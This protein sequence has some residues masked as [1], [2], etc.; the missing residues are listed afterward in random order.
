MKHLLI[1][2][3]FLSS[4]AV[5]GDWYSGKGSVSPQAKVY[6]DRQIKNDKARKFN[7]EQMKATPTYET[8]RERR[9]RIDDSYD[10]YYESLQ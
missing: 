2:L 7:Y 1:L 10:D 9:Q 4:Y 5:A 8:E 6:I 3:L